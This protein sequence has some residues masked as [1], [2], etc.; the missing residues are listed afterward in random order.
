MANKPPL[1]K[2]P[3]NNLMKF[4][5]AQGLYVGFHG[6]FSHRDKY[7]RHEQEELLYLS[8]GNPYWSIRGVY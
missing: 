8:V 1:V 6:I 4:I 3:P 2:S 5:E 7:L